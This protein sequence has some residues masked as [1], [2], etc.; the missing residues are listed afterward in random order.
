MVRHL[1][2]FYLACLRSNAAKK[3]FLMNFC[4]FNSDRTFAFGNIC[5]KMIWE[6]FALL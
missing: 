1:A 2:P 6:Q 5:Q 3:S 4:A